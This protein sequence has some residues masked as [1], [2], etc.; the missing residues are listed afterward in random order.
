MFPGS[1]AFDERW[2]PSARSL[3]AMGN[4]VELGYYTPY[5]NSFRRFRRS[6]G[7]GA[8]SVRED[9]R[10]LA[11]N[12]DTHVLG[13]LENN[14]YVVSE[15]ASGALAVVDPALGGE[16]L[17]E[18]LLPQA[19]RVAAI[20]LTHAHFDHVG[21]LAEFRRRLRAPVLM[22]EAELELL[23]NASEHGFWLGVEGI[24]QPSDPDRFA[25]G[26]ERITV[27]EDSLLVLETPGH[28]PGGLSF[29][30]ESSGFVITGDALFFESVGR[31][32]L[33]GASPQRLLK[34]IREKLFTLPEN[35]VV[36]PG[37]GPTTTIGHEK[38][39][40]PYL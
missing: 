34:S 35:T 6:E 4:A 7:R 26:G 31:T 37:H 30:S 39:A 24:D 8:E 1:G 21:G 27:G 12:I 28:S 10:S 40:N 29:Y 33:P 36:Y 15:P 17:L 9:G 13:P 22:H 11:L 3:N 19:E 20:L 18:E 16:A 25:T 14:V 2:R 38:T 23:Q 5:P 32:D